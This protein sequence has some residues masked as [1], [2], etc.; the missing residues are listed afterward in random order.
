M[1]RATLARDPA[2]SA[3][4]ANATGAAAA[5]PACASACMPSRWWSTSAIGVIGT[6]NFDPRGDH[7]NTESAVVIDDPGVRA[8]AGRQHP[9]ATS[10]RTTPGRSRARDK[11][12]VFSGL[13]YSLAKM[14]ERLPIFDLWP[15]RYATSYEFEPGPDARRRCRRIDPRFR[16]CYRPVG[17]FPEVRHRPEM[18]GAD[19]DL[20]RLRRG[21]VPD[22]VTASAAVAATRHRQP[23]SGRVG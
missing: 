5:A 7:Y 22:P 13:E 3:R 16:G 9:S 20:H 11:P 6:H 15:V 8:R 18:A 17:D 23:G 2:H 10:R 14:S 12:P 1:T 19:A 4:G 21:A